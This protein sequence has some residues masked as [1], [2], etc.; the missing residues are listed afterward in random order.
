M[1]DNLLKDIH[2]ITYN[3]LYMV[4]HKFKKGANVLD[5]NKLGHLKKDGLKIQA[6]EDL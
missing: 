3:I 6:K 5:C 2:G 4:N 1:V